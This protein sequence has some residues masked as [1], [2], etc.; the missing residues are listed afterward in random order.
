MAHLYILSSKELLKIIFVIFT[1]TPTYTVQ[2]AMMSK[3]S[4]IGE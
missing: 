4:V 1:D 2:Y 3:I